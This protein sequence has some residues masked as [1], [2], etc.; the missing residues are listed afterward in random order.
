MLANT[1]FLCSVHNVGILIEEEMRQ[2][3]VEFGGHADITRRLEDDFE[4]G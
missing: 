3:L 4:H 2:A 1:N